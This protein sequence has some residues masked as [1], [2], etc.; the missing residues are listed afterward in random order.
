MADLGFD[1]KVAIITGAGLKAQCFSTADEFVNSAIL[2]EPGCILLDL[3]M[4]GLSGLELQ[5]RLAEMAPILPIGVIL[6]RT[7]RPKIRSRFG[8][9]LGAA[10]GKHDGHQ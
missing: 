1:G 4:P 10:A 5:N 9:R 8:G 7:L 2:P 6:E 3:Q